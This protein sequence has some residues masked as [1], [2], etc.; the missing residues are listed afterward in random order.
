[1]RNLLTNFIILLLG[2]DGKTMMAMLWAQEIMN[3]ETTEEAKA[4][5]NRVP[6]LLKEKVKKILIN[7][8]FE[9]LTTE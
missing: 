4:L 3:A 1:M 5:Y 6:R 9:E 7:S 8:G 2:K